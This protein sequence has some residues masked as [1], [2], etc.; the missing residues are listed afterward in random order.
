MES[1][2]GMSNNTITSFVNDALKS[3]EVKVEDLIGKND[4]TSSVADAMKS[5]EA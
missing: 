2:N 1:L 3:L 4:S 5:L